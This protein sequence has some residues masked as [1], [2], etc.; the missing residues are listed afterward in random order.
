MRQS[1]AQN[2]SLIENTVHKIDSLFTELHKN[3]NT[4]RR[5][6]LVFE[7]VFSIIICIYNYYKLQN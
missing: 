5:F 4:L 7:C 2:N 1:D 3:L 6:V